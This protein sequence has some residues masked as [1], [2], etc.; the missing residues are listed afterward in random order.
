MSKQFKVK[1]PQKSL[2]T[3]WNH[4]PFVRSKRSNVIVKRSL[5]S[6]TPSIIRFHGK[7]IFGGVDCSY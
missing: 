3:S 2:K 6:K 4:E 1:A 5:A 7:V